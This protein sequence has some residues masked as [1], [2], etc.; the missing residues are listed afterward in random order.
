MARPNR[1]ERMRNRKPI[2]RTSAHAVR[3]SNEKPGSSAE[4][5]FTASTTMIATAVRTMRRRSRRLAG[6]G[7]TGR[8]SRNQSRH[9]SP[10]FATP[11]Y[12]PLPATVTPSLHTELI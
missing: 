1:T 6:V 11:R 9:D 8:S 10:L 3:T 2:T 12:C 4:S 7:A 5:R